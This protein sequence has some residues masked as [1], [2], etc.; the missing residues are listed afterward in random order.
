[1]QRAVTLD[2]A[3]RD[4]ARRRELNIRIKVRFISALETL[5]N[6]NASR[7]SE[8]LTLDDCFLLDLTLRLES[9]E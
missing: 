2:E 1:M 6:E 5:A 3:R 8:L 4:E 9:L 7:R